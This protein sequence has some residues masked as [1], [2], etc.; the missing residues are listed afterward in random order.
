MPQSKPP[1]TP[2]TSPLTELVRTA[3][4]AGHVGRAVLEHVV[5]LVA[6][7][8]SEVDCEGTPGA[9]VPGDAVG[10]ALV[11]VDVLAGFLALRADADLR[12][13]LC[14]V[15]ER[16]CAA[17]TDRVSAWADRLAAAGN[18]STGEELASSWRAVADEIRHHVRACRAGNG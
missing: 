16:F 14:R 15:A 12:E 3:A 1:P 5:V 11:V 18:T 10:L 6:A 7:R 9:V 4:E 13:A 17:I 8:V 2:S